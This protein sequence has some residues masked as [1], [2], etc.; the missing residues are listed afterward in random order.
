MGRPPIGKFT[1]VRLSAE[2]LARID[3]VAATGKRAEFI[4]AAVDQALTRAEADAAISP[5]PARQWEMSD[6]AVLYAA[7]IAKGHKRIAD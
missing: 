2:T 5:A 4:R 1:A 3:A 7:M 6:P